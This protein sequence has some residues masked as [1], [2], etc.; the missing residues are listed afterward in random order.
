MNRV[1]QRLYF[2]TFLSGAAGLIYELVWTRQLALVFGSTTHTIAAVVSAFLGG[3]ALGSVLGGWVSESIPAHRRLR[4]YAGL[5]VGIGA[6]A[7]AVTFILPHLTPFYA[8]F[9]DGSST[10]A[11]LI[12]LKFG[13][14][15]FVVIVP[16]I[17]MGMTLPLLMRLM[18]SLRSESLATNLS[19][20]YALNTLGAVVGVA[21]AAV[22]LIEVLGLRGSAWAAAALNLTAGFLVGWRTNAG[23]NPT[24]SSSAAVQ[25]KQ[26]S[27]PAP[28][29]WLS[30]A[31]TGFIALAFEV[32]WT[33][34]LTPLTGT[35]IYAFAAVLGMYLLGIV[36]GSWI[37]GRL[38]ARSAT[39]KYIFPFSQLGL[40]VCVLA[41]V[42]LTR[43]GVPID[44]FA[45][46][47]FFF[48]LGTVFMGLSLPAAF[49]LLRDTGRHGRAV[50]VA[51]AYNTFGS[52]AGT[53]I[54]S[55]VFIPRLG[56]MQSILALTAPTFFL[57]SLWFFVLR[58]RS[59]KSRSRHALAIVPIVAMIVV[60]WLSVS[61]WSALHEPTIQS[62]TDAAQRKNISYRFYE[63][64]VASVFAYHDAKNHRD[65]LIVDGVAMTSL[66]A[67]T[68]LMAHLPFALH[69]D[70]QA[71]LV[72]AFGMGTTYR[73]A[74]LDGL[75]VDAV[76][77]SP[78]VPKMMDIF[79]PDA[80]QFLHHP[81]GRIIIN[82]GRNYVRL[83]SKQY[84]LVAIDPPPPFNSAG[85]T[86]LYARDFYRQISTHLNPGGLVSQ[87][88]FF[89]S[90]EDDLGMSIRSF[91][92][93]FP[94]VMAFG[95]PGETAGIYLVGSN[96]PIKI[97]PARFQT[98]FSSPTVT[99]DFAAV[100]TT[101]SGKDAAGLLIA[102]HDELVAFAAKF[103]AV[104]DDRPRTEYF[105]LRHA[106]RSYPGMQYAFLNGN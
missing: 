40:G 30:V 2:A 45:V 93:V 6:L 56:S 63:D 25:M 34:I 105:L 78:S 37:Y 68:K 35:Y 86:V 67:E 106:F 33:R 54:A 5:E 91:T 11:S 28:F 98:V 72:V 27:L 74:L 14:S 103:P 36:V 53:T 79:T 24:K 12:F 21:L 3:L 38:D 41:A 58:D 70:P 43:P 76:E 95:S 81:R 61:Q 82:D 13:L 49:G 90:R 23:S 51:Y 62:L 101:L 57:A 50:G 17:L 47:T 22:V 15:A 85:T 71:M 20:L 60:T 52:I 7:V 65:N 75:T 87:W 73:S 19:R 10:T 1:T 39:V 31:L 89:G 44:R 18:Q 26:F 100:N 102:N 8:R 55:F 88:L 48:S 69:P 66:G 32:L 97:N 46:F 9:S 64:E 99:Q 4:F 16:T 96:T 80:E 77:L 92:D 42:I 29:I 104:T 59:L 84:D 83:T 94:Y